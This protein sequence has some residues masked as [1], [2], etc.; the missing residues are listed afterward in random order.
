MTET[1]LLLGGSR[2]YGFP[3]EDSDWDVVV[4]TDPETAKILRGAFPRGGK[5]PRNTSI[6]V[7]DLNIILATSRAEYE[8]WAKGIKELKA[9][10]PVEKAEAIRVFEELR[11][12]LKH[13]GL[14]GYRQPC[15]C[16]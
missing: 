10:A 12:K 13:C 1:P 6:K 3:R 8:V 14:C 9:R 2:V 4:L 7:G 16:L 15:Q 5:S 11:I